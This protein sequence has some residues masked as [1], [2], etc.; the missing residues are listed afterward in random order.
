MVVNKINLS[1][2]IRGGEEP[3]TALFA[4]MSRFFTGL[5]WD[6]LEGTFCPSWRGLPDICAFKTWGGVVILHNIHSYFY[7]SIQFIFNSIRELNSI[8]YN[9]FSIQFESSV[10]FN[11]IHFQFNSTVQFNSI[12]FCFWG[13]TIQNCLLV[14]PL[15]LLFREI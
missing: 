1:L 4:P 15:C 3:R 5:A 6:L 13:A 9:S 14:L 10:Q 2:I 12:S 11:T 7:I 8:Q